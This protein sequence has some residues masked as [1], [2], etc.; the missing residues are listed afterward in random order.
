[1]QLRFPLV[2]I[3]MGLAL[4]VPVEARNWVSTTGGYWVDRDSV[5]RDGDIAYFF[6]TWTPR[7]RLPGEVSTGA[8]YAYNCRT[9]FLYGVQD[10][11]L[12][13]PGLSSTPSE[14]SSADAKLYSSLLCS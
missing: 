7:D 4:A 1:M 2:P 11:R 8:T 6:Q 10:G 13:A 12:V 5:R 14:V 3:A 9:R